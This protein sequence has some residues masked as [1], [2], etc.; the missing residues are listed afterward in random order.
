MDT[1]RESRSGYST[2][3]VAT[4]VAIARRY[5]LED[6]SKVA[7]AREFDLSRFQVARIL[8]EARDRGLVRIQIAAEGYIDAELSE[9]LRT[10]LGLRRAIAVGAIPDSTTRTVIHHLGRALADLLAEVVAEGTV[11]GLAWSR[12]EASMVKQLDRLE[13]CT[14][15]QLAGHLSAA[16]DTSGSVEAVRQAAEISGGAAYPIYAP[17]VVPDAATASGLLRSHDIATALAH[18]D[19]M[20]TAVVSIGAWGSAHSRVYCQVSEAEQRRARQLGVCGEISGRLYTADGTPVPELLGDRVVA[21]TLAQLAA[22]DD[23]IATGWGAETAPAVRAAVEAGWV[24]TLLV[25]DSLARALV[26]GKRSDHKWHPS[27]GAT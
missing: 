8:K 18:A 17:M 4:A 6:A 1:G 7:L 14:V 2:Q 20:D 12:V 5:Y 24:S 3:D 10:E 16:D 11:L 9:Q 21:M 19:L 22:C 15:V 13:R 27:S 25:D 23:V 26:D